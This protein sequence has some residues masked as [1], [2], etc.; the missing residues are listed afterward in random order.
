MAEDDKKQ[1]AARYVAVQCGDCGA[2]MRAR[3]WHEGITCPKCASSDVH[4]L[5]APG[6]A[7]DYI[8]ADR[9]QGTT[10]ADVMFGDW[11]RWCGFITSNQFN[12]AVHRQNSELQENDRSTPIHELMVRMGFIDE[13]R[14]HGLL[15]FLTTPRP[16]HDDEDFV[17]RLLQ[18]PGIDRA[19]VRKV[20]EDQKALAA[21]RNEVPPICQLL[22]QDRVIDESTMLEI[23]REEEHEGHGALK[24]ALAM[25][26]PAPKE[27]VVSKLGKR[28][29]ESP[30]FVRNVIV[31]AVL[32]VVTIGVWAWRL[33]GE[34]QMCYIKCSACGRTS[35][36][37][38][39]ATEWPARC[40]GCRTYSGE[41][42]A[43]CENGHV[44]T[45]PNPYN[46][47]PCPVCGTRAS[48]LLTEED[49]ARGVR[50]AAAEETG[51]Y[52]P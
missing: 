22:V 38:W 10:S 26:M 17:E 36:V 52:G 23:L 7:V 24:M 19:R 49:V 11:A 41:I 51:T 40:P 18:R 32:V 20:E 16:N 29:A 30:Q 8:L 48:R 37:E 4:P 44:F 34:T 14:A 5:P 3:G 45:W 28:A 1:G 12:Q 47:R 25:S 2:K 21:K 50:P 15:R 27:T 43:I 31:L 9:S 33:S 42:A 6:G 46:A 35:Q 13:E 39:T